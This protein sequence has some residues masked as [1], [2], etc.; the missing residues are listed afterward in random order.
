MYMDIWR[1]ILLESENQ[2]DCQK[3]TFKKKREK[4]KKEG[5]KKQNMN[6]IINTSSD[7]CIRSIS[8]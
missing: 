7:P 2:N 4:K 8:L 6:K 1:L 5:R 3:T